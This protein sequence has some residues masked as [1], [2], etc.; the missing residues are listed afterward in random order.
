MKKC[1]LFFGAWCLVLGASA[2]LEEFTESGYTNI[3]GILRA[4]LNAV[5]RQVN[6]NNHYSM[7]IG[8][9][10]WPAGDP[11]DRVIYDANTNAFEPMAL[12]LDT[13]P[14]GNIGANRVLALD[15]S[16]TVRE[17]LILAAEG[18]ANIEMY[19][20]KATN[21]VASSSDGAMYLDASSVNLRY[22]SGYVNN[23][24]NY[25]KGEFPADALLNMLVAKT[26]GVS[27]GRASTPTHPFQV[28]N[29]A[30]SAP[31][32]FYVDTNGNAHVGND[33]TIAGDVEAL[34]AGTLTLDS[35][36][37]AWSDIGLTYSNAVRINSAIYVTNDA[38][39]T[40]WTTDG[41]LSGTTIV[42]DSGEYLL[43]PT[44]TNGIAAY[45]LS[46][47]GTVNKAV[48]AVVGTN[49]VSIPYYGGDGKLRIDAS[50][51]VP[52]PGEAHNSVIVQGVLVGVENR[53]EAQLSKTVTRIDLIEDQP[54]SYSATKRSYVD[55][56]AADANTYA[57]GI[58][59]DYADDDEKTVR[60]AQLRLNRNWQAKAHGS[61]HYVL[62]AGEIAG[63]GQLVGNTNYFALAQND[64]E[65]MIFSADA[66]GL[67]ISDFDISLTSSN[68]TV[69]LY[70][71]T[72]GVNSAPYAEWCTDLIPGE[73]SSPASY[74]SN[75]YPTAV[76]TNYVL[77]FTVDA[78]DTGYF[79][80]MQA[81][82][83]S[84]VSVEADVFDFGD[85][86]FILRDSTDNRWK[87]EVSTGGVLTTTDLDP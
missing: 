47:S 69:M 84:V 33:M 82:G 8:S 67:Y 65:L 34:T 18:G 2:Q 26:N 58:L 51:G 73:W 31:F 15:Y 61:T 39:W 22:D 86:Y 9:T 62:S 50:G 76:G 36:I 25:L 13:G 23:S 44:Q 5:I 46:A 3:G 60:G 19:G 4:K 63:N 68:A 74:S 87:V 53:A 78:P 52:I 49:T 43:S 75:S 40:G 12:S 45:A 10:N 80:A 41:D 38:S 20:R 1:I 30:W 57:D 55:A 72:N 17:Y 6:T 42:L 77:E 11:G 24:N 79:R 7:V 21:A 48:S 28:W 64:Q 83:E 70:V 54:Y 27:V 59:D 71:A 35:A 16:D 14:A 66:S 29:S 37:S 32:A 85:A 81:V 56:A